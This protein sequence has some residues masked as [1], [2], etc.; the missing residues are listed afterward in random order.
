[1]I[2]YEPNYWID[3]DDGEL[4]RL[5]WM[6][7]KLRPPSSIVSQ[8]AKLVKTPFSPGKRWEKGRNVNARPEHVALATAI[9]VNDT[10]DASFALSNADFLVA[11]RV[12]ASPT[13]YC[14]SFS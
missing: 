2:Q 4:K 14:T 10:I 1:M 11:G 3:F 8:M 9:R 5:S 7:N 12:K 6:V 13:S